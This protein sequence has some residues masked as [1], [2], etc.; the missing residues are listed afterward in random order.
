M[1][2]LDL[3]TA[4]HEDFNVIEE[5][6]EGSFT[7][8]PGNSIAL[9]GKCLLDFTYPFAD[10]DLG[11]RALGGFEPLLEILVVVKRSACT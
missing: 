1:K 10:A 8:F 7:F 5:L 9:V 11:S 3:K 6:V 4:N 2:D